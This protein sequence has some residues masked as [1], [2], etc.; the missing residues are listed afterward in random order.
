ME[1]G[2]ACVEVQRDRPLLCGEGGDSDVAVPTRQLALD[3][4]DPA[5]GRALAVDRLIQGGELILEVRR[6]L[7][8]LGPRRLELL[9]RHLGRSRGLQHHEQDDD[10]QNGSPHATSAGANAKSTDASQGGESHA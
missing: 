9:A 6:D 7:G 5:L 2:G 10:E 3:R 8:D 4:R 1:T